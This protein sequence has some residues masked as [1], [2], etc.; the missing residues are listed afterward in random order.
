MSQVGHADS[1]MTMDVYAQMQQR[2]KRDNGAKFD[3]LIRGAREQV[4]GPANGPSAGSARIN[5]H[6]FGT[7]NGTKGQKRA[8]RG[9]RRGPAGPAKHQNIKTC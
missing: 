9:L 7:T 6:R 8:S 3:K 5:R 2:A 1:K 4:K